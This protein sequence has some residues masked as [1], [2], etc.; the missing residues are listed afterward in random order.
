[1]VDVSSAAGTE[2]R[3]QQRVKKNAVIESLLKAV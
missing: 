1:V 2:Q 3:L